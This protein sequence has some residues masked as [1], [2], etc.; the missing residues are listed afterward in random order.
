MVSW[1]DRFRS[2]KRFKCF[3]MSMVSCLHRFCGVNDFMV[4]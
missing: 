1:F 4:S 2:V 3:M